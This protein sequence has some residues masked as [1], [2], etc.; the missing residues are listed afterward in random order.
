MPR[1]M[2]LA[3]GDVCG[4]HIVLQ[5]LII[6]A[7]LIVATVSLHGKLRVFTVIGEDK[8]TIKY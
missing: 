4:R 3:G 5:W 7:S 2:E 8:Q 1:K 6:L